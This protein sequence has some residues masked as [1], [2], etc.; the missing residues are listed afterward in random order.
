MIIIAA[1][2]F[3]VCLL[4]PS[5]VSRLDRMNFAFSIFLI[6]AIIFY[7][8]VGL[9]MVFFGFDVFFVVDGL[10]YGTMFGIMD[11]L[12]HIEL[13]F[14]FIDD[15]SVSEQVKILKLNIMYDK[16]FRSLFLFTTFLVAIIVSAGL[17]WILA[18][19]EK[20]RFIVAISIV[21]IGLYIS[22]GILWCIYWNVIKKINLIDSKILSLRKDGTA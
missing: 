12:R 10:V 9:S 14:S 13:D 5:I 3:V 20:A 21:V 15:N 22:I 16:W 1:A 11:G 19:P 18:T 6:D 4:V 7:L 2:L 17:Q 8:A